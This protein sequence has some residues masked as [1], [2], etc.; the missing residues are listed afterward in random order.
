LFNPCSIGPSVRAGSRGLLN[1]PTLSRGFVG[2]VAADDAARGGAEDTVMTGKVP[3]GAAHQRAFDAAFGIGRQRQAN[4]S[5]R[6]RGASEHLLLHQSL[7][8]IENVPLLRRCVSGPKPQ[9]ND[10]A[11]IDRR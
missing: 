2:L 8:V 1:D 9:D 4:E 7:L 6:Y 5:K 10:L 11:P 3:R